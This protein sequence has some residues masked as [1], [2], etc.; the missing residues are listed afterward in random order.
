MT[1]KEQ[2]KHPKWQRKRLEI[3][4]RDKWKCLICNTEGDETNQL[5]IH[6]LYYLPGLMAWDYEDESLK[7]CCAKCHH[8]LTFDLSKL[9]GLI[10]WQ[11]ITSKLI[12]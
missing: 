3:F 6:H 5:T 8:I 9:S 12:L 10:A 4:D 1:Y 2:L 11:I 7:T